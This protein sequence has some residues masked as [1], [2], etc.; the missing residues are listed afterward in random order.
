M[1]CCPNDISSAPSKWTAFP[2]ATFALVNTGE[3]ASSVPKSKIE[4][5]CGKQSLALVGF[6]NDSLSW[7]ETQKENVHP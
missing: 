6:H 5:F 7:T 1:I 3:L 4:L 2:K